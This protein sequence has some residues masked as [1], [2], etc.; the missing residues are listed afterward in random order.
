MDE[1]VLVLTSNSK[2]CIVSSVDCIVP[3][4]VP[5]ISSSPVFDVP[6]SSWESLR[7]YLEQCRALSSEVEVGED[8]CKQAEKDFV[9]G[10]QGVKPSVTE[11]DLHLWLNLTRFISSS[12][13][14][15]VATLEHYTRAKVLEE[16][17]KRR[18]V[19]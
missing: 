2:P 18:L 12:F 16:E 11:Q 6:P 19:L 9:N 1:P 15:R 5:L 3:L 14:S 10:R 7:V 8:V 4:S 13:G 17:R